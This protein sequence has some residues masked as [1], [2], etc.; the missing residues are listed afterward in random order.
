[1]AM[2]LMGCLLGTLLLAFK[3]DFHPQY[4]GFFHRWFYFLG[5]Y[6]LPAISFPVLM[7]IIMYFIGFI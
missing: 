2:L 6:G 3:K 7:L 4:R 1:M 5:R